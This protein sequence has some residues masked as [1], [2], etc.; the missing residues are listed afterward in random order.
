MHSEF[1]IALTAGLGGM[2][3]W[4]FADFFAKKTI[5]EVGSVVTLFWGHVAGT[6]AL[7]L[8]LAMRTATG[9]MPHAPA[10]LSSWGILI[11]FGILQAIVYLLVYVGFG[12]GQLAVL[13]PV[14][15]SFP[16]FVALISV[17]AFGERLGH[18]VPIP[19]AAIFG[20]V[21]LFNI[22]PAALRQ[23]RIAIA[24]V[25]GFTEVAFATLLA[26]IWTISWQRFIS[27]HDWLFYATVM[28]AAMT[29]VA[30]CIARATSTPLSLR[31]FRLWMFLIPIG[32]CE[33]IAY[34]AIS[35]GYSRTSMTSTIAILSGAFS[36]P[37]I[38][39]ARAFLKERVT[40]IQV[41]GTAVTIAGVILLACL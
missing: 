17:F 9:R 3:G 4:G 1:Y 34:L 8:A 22:D 35:L 14:F 15:A 36:L 26:A 33:A 29:V 27:G 38:V 12:K 18:F 21:I 28:Y 5:D 13:N 19:L 32:V 23:R 40:T 16:G 7:A 24:R 6:F 11:A 37:T 25:P 30:Y 10:D 2:L 41:V 31:K 20:G 39:L